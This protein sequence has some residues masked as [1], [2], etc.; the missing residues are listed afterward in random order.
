M[1]GLYPVPYATFRKEGSMIR[2]KLPNVGTTIFTVIGDLAARHQAL[3]LSQGAPSFPCD[4]ALVERAAAAM[5][6]GH[7]Q[8]AGMTGLAALREAISAKYRSLYS[9]EYDPDDEV[10]IVASASQGLYAA[11]AGLVHPGDEVIYFDPA[12]DSYAPLVR[13]QG[14][15]PI[16]VP[17]TPDGFRVPWDLVAARITPRTRMIIVNTPHNPTATVFSGQDL[18]RLAELTLTDPS[19]IS[20]VVARLVQR[21]LVSRQRAP[22]DARRWVVT[23]SARGRTLLARAPE[24][25]QRQLI[26]TLAGQPAAHLELFCGVLEQLN[27]SLGVTPGDVNLFFEAGAA[28]PRRS[29]R[30]S[31]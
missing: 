1:L 17:L 22:D 11:I 19:S 14:A 18:E 9:V 3:N 29:R 21:R 4:P 26:E 12:F 15:V 6:A 24:P 23:V 28:R 30:A 31:R 25:Y 5:R 27:R 10:T 7:N 8:Y 20:V 16:A 2:S 13:L